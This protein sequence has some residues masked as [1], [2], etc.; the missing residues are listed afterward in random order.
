MRSAIVSVVV[1]ALIIGAIIAIPH[2]QAQVE[3]ARVAQ[4]SWDYKVVHVM[5]L[6]DGT[7]EVDEITASLEKHL[8]SLGKDGWEL[9]Q[10]VNGGWVF[11]RKR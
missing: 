10:E 3:Q 8:N 9:C 6:I 7:R 1:A 4:P 2:S 11:K 5:K